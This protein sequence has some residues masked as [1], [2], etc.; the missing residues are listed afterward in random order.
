MS[1]RRLSSFPRTVRALLIGFALWVL[2]IGAH[3]WIA[4]AIYGLGLAYAMHRAMRETPLL[5][6]AQIADAEDEKRRDDG[7]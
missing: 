5:S 1:A 4:A 3:L 2:L 7:E 6:G